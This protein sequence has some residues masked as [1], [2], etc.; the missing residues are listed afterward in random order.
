MNSV[1]D[2]DRPRY[3]TC[4]VTVIV[5][6]YNC[7]TTIAQTLDSLLE[8]TLDDWEAVIVNDA[9]TDDSE[10][11][12]TS[13]VARDPRFRLVNNRE[14][15]GVSASRNNALERATG[16]FINLL[17]A[18]DWLV[19]D[20]LKTMVNTCD[21]NPE[22]AGVYSDWT[23]VLPTGEHSLVRSHDESHVSFSALCISNRFQPPCIMFSTKV[24]GSAGRFDP[25]FRRAGDRDLWIRVYRAGFKFK[26][27]DKS[28][29]CYRDNPLSLT[30]N[31]LAQ[32]MEGLRV[33]EYAHSNDSRCLEPLPEYENGPGLSSKEKAYEV[34]TR[35]HL[36]NA[37]VRSDRNG[38]IGISQ[39]M[40]ENGIQPVTAQSLAKAVA[41]LLQSSHSER[42]LS[43]RRWQ[44][45]RKTIDNVA[46]SAARYWGDEA[47]GRNFV[48]MLIRTIPR[49]N[50]TFSMF[51]TYLRYGGY[52]EPLKMLR[53]LKRAWQRD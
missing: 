42:A 12:I 7:E 36:R 35:L 23:V 38:V 30:H 17:D 10:V 45:I 14:N 51:L 16:R 43:R 2:L 1:S 49:G 13:Y 52:R 29:G 28:L 11:V 32:W 46:Y 41:T 48:S 44:Q 9:S 8:Q 21:R 50:Y 5:P 3:K 6:C 24:L 4:A 40:V 37:I 31:H 19:P 34:L 53:V 18:D 39:R 47:Y 33:V 25:T 15:L 27:I 22:Y 26:R 20:A